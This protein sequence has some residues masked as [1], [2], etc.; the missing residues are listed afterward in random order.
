MVALWCCDIPQ[1]TRSVKFVSSCFFCGRAGDWLLMDRQMDVQYDKHFAVAD[2]VDE[3]KCAAR[4]AAV[5]L[6]IDY[7]QVMILTILSVSSLV[8][9][10]EL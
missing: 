5:R 10:K 8:K 3:T 4:S 1:P 9:D 6:Q 2:D 7:Q